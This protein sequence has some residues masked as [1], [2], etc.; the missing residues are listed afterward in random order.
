[1]QESLFSVVKIAYLKRARRHRHDPICM[2]CADSRR[3]WHSRPQSTRLT[4]KRRALG[5]EWAVGPDA[6]NITSRARPA[7]DQ[8]YDYRY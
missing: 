2:S 5:P 6:V 7:R 1:M 3:G 4:K 8:S